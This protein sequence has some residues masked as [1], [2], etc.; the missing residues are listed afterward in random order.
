MPSL[1]PRPEPY[2]PEIAGMLERYPR[3]PD[4]RLL[5]L[6]RVFAQ[7]ARFLGGRGPA[8]LLDAASPLSLR[9]RELVILRVTARARCSYE[10]GVHVAAFAQRAGLTATQITAT[11][12]RDASAD[13]W[14]PQEILLLRCVDALCDGADLPAELKAPFQDHWSLA[15]Q[16]EITALCGTYQTIAM[17]ANLAALA[18]E[19]GA[20]VLPDSGSGFE[21]VR[22]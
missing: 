7:S 15:Q 5:S 13:C 16:L 21:A 8:N 11:A 1:T 2:P 10:W 9:E 17:V 19:P 4:G 20:P 3:G 14:E 12:Q 18:P 22:G 6:F